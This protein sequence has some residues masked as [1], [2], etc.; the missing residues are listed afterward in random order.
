MGTKQVVNLIN[1]YFTPKNLDPL[2][3]VPPKRHTP[4]RQLQKIL[5]THITAKA[6]SGASTHCFKQADATIL[7]NVHKNN[8]GPTLILPNLQT[9]KA[10][11]QG[12]LPISLSRDSTTVHIFDDD[13]LRNA[14]LISLGQLCDDDCT[15]HLDKNKLLVFKNKKKIIQGTRNHTDGLWDV[16]F[17]TK[18]LTE[19]YAKRAIKGSKHLNLIIHRDKTKQE[20]AAYLHACAFSPPKSTFLNAIANNNFITWPGLSTSLIRRMVL[21]TAT[22]KGH[23]DQERK[24][25]QSTR[26]PIPASLPPVDPDKNLKTKNLICALEPFLPKEK[27]FSDLTGR[28]PHRSSRGTEYLLVVYHHDSN[29]ILVEP[30]KNRQAAEITRAWKN[31]HETLK[32]RGEQ[33]KI[34]ILDNEVSNDLK[35][36]FLKNKVNFELIPPHMHRRNAAERAI[37]TFKNHFLAGLATCDPRFPLAEWDRLLNQAQLTLNL[38]RQSRLNLNSP[39]MLTSLVTLTLI[40]HH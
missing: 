36:A 19:H 3:D 4:I 12:T 27:A 30:V 15:V 37:R 23:L 13:D 2:P 8:N 29:A 17:P 40:S 32:Q 26:I 14:S 18:Q 9:I 16:H 39:H 38:L 33:P 24:N 35:K 20:L 22:A 11:S 25:L 1:N 28:F 7:N 5:Q 21:P 34:Y 31:I 6:D 10:K